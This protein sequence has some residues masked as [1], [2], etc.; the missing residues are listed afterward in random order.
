[1][2][3]STKIA[4]WYASGLLLSLVWPLRYRKGMKGE[5]RSFFTVWPIHGLFGPLAL[6][7]T[8]PL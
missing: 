8:F 7:T 4:L 1:M 3:L 2:D 5:W 6:L